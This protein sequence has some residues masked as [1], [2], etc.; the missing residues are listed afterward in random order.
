MDEP[1]AKEKSIV[2]ILSDSWKIFKKN[3]LPILL[4]V[5]VVYLPLKVLMALISVGNVGARHRFF[6]NID[7]YSNGAGLVE[8]L[9][10]TLATISVVLIAKSRI[11]GKSLDFR[12]ALK[13]AAGR[14]LPAIGTELLL[15]LLL[16]GLFLLLIV[17]GVIFGIFWGFALY[18]VAL[19]EKSGMGALRYSKAMVKGRW[20]K[21]FGYFLVFGLLGGAVSLAVLSPFSFLRNNFF[22][23]VSFGMLEKI[24]GAF[25]IVVG[26]VF[27]L[28]M[29]KTMAGPS[30]K[31]RNEVLVRKE[32][33]K[34]KPKLDS[35][36][37]SAGDRQ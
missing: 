12:K 11:D 15:I 29:E 3:I 4:A 19:R 32:S 18:A 23:Q 21:V 36:L 37:V 22:T 30:E 28:D 31:K 34:R 1:V 20:P 27:F 35:S 24:V 33:R 9:V 5:A 26:T 2:E 13:K 10:G 25:F 8:F 6:G 16:I 17:P 14:W 7:L